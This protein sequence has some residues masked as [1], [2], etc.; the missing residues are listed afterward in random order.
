MRSGHLLF[1][2]ALLAGWSFAGGASAD[3]VPPQTVG[4]QSLALGAVCD[5]TDA[6]NRPTG[7]TGVCSQTVCPVTNYV[8]ATVGLGPCVKC[9]PPDAGGPA[10]ADDGGAV[11]ASV[12]ASAG[13]GGGPVGDGA[14]G[15]TSGAQ[16]GSYPV[17]VT[18]TD[19]APRRPGP[20]LGTGGT[21]QSTAPAEPAQSADG[22][23][24]ISRNGARALGPWL[25]ATAG[26]ALLLRKR[27]RRS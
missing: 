8:D 26:C 7:Q 16:A 11:D 19:A 21:A 17:T 23:C 3:V 27:R 18:I 2:S 20:T 13:A 14:S 10:P 15:G 5:I 1:V 9:L 24:S 22:G 25:L 6:W 12:E 4:C